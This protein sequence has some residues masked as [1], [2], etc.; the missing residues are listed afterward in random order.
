MKFVLSALCVIFA[1]QVMWNCLIL[2]QFAFILI[3]IVLIGC[4]RSVGSPRR[5]FPMHNGLGRPCQ[6]KPLG[7]GWRYPWSRDCD[8]AGLRQL[9]CSSHWCWIV[10]MPARILYP[11]RW[12]CTQPFPRGY[13][14]TWESYSVRSGPSLR[15]PWVPP[16]IPWCGCGCSPWCPRNLL[17]S[18]RYRLVPVPFWGPDPRSIERMARTCLPFPGVQLLRRRPSAQVLP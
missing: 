10:R 11:I 16:G 3:I 6:D 2:K 13:C 18:G 4:L 17:R 1:C 7:T 14:P 5:W 12:S 8:Q 9:R 15:L